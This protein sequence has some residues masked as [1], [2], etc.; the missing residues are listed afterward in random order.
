MSPPLSPPELH[1]PD[2]PEVHLGGPAAA[3]AG[4]PR[5]RLGLWFA[6]RQGLGTY[7]PLLLMAALA[8]GTGWLV[9]NSPQRPDALP[10][11]APREAP[12]YTMRTFSI[13][14]FDDTGR[15]AL[16][17]D[18]DVLR[19]YPLTDRLDID[20]VRI[21]AIAP[22]GRVTDASARRALANGDGSE[23]QLMG[24]AE[25]RSQI[26]ADDTLVLRSE[27]LHAFLRFERVRTHLP[28]HIT[29]GGTVTQ[30][31]GMDYDHVQQ[32]LQLSGPVRTLLPPGTGQRAP[33]VV[34]R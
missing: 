27:F 31:G 20:G 4:P 23:V 19:H 34:A 29:R 1:L 8:V 28:V 25:V 22:D 11:A 3:P 24:N 13:T 15:V 5:P 12:D 30:A 2:L 10:A 32:L 9:K 26:G 16:R 14:R 33:A 21:H 6:V 18:G 7:L 17:I